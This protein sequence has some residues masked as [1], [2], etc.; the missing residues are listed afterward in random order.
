MPIR[1]SLQGGYEFDINPYDQGFLPRYS[2]LYAFTNI[3]KSAYSTDIY[4]SQEFQFGEF[5][6][7]LNE[8]MKSTESKSIFS[9]YI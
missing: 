2:T 7:G 3:S 9:K 4:L 6:V 1:F 8:V 5:S